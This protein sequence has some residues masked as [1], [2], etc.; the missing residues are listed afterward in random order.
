MKAKT[1]RIEKYVALRLADFADPY[2]RS[3]S[4]YG[5]SAEIALLEIQMTGAEKAIARE[6]LKAEKRYL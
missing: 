6:R 5:L 1:P 4:N 2:H 3:R